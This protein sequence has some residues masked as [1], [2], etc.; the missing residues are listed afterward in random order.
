MASIRI[1]VALAVLACAGIAAAD[2]VVL[3][4]GQRLQGEIASLSQGK[5]VLRTPYAG[6][7]ALRWSDV[8]S[9]STTRPV[10]LMRKGAS[11]PQQGTL[12]AL[13][14]GRVLLVTRE[15]EALE[16]ALDEIAYLNPKP[17]ESGVG[18]AYAGR[19]TLSAAYTRG[20]TED[21]R[22]HGEAEFTARARLYRYTLS[23]LADRRD[24][25]LGGV[26][27]AWRA[28]GNYDRFLKPDRFLYARGSLEHDRAKDIAQRA[29][30][31]GGYGADLVDTPRASLSVRA[32]LDYVTLDRYVGPNERYPAFGWGVKATYKPFFHENEGFW[33]L[34]D[35]DTV[36]VRSKTGIRFPL[37]QGLG[38][39]AQLNLDW[40]SEPAPGRKSTD[41]TLLVGVDYAW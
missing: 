41:S 37:W 8:T 4:S 11:A 27:T 25:P 22:L 40:E 7:I 21:E 36:T 35:T 9:L 13:F 23:A 1:A 38:F 5:L 18:V 20:N 32:G 26:N 16:L 39:S 2:E 6:E 34:E 3:R 29:A 24:E 28:G 12:Q 31:G 14:D 15:G 19:F 30:V 33:N 10:A 17:W